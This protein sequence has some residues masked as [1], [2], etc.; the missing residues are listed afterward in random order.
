MVIWKAMN[1]I[2]NN[3]RTQMKLNGLSLADLADKLEN[4]VS[5]QALHRYVKGEVIPDN[6]MIEKLSKV[7]NVHINKL[8]QAPSDRVKVEL[9]EIRYFKF[10]SY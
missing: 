8:I 1:I 10:R 5:R 3:I 9:G 7:F 6:V 4:I 2:G